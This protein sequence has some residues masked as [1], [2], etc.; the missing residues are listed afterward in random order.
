MSTTASVPAPASSRLRRVAGQP[1]PAEG[2]GGL[3]TQSWF[4]IALSAEIGTSCLRG[5]DFL[6]G[7]VI[8]FRDAEGTA[9]VMTAYCPHLGADLSV[10]DV[11]E[12]TVRC[13]FHHWRYDCT[14]RCVSTKVGDPPPAAARLYRFRSVE[15]YGI[16][17]AFNGDDPWWQ[18][19]SF[20]YPDDELTIRAIELP[21]TL[22]V[23]PWVLCC[24]T[25]DMQHI[26][27]LHGITFETG[28]PHDQIEWTDHSLMY[29]FAGLHRRGEQV[30]NRIGVFGTSLYY[31][32]TELDG[33][34]FGFLAPFGLPRPGTSRVFL[35]VAA[36]RD[37]GTAPEVE[38]FLDR[39][40]ALEQS[41]VGEDVA[42][43]QTIH[44][45]PGTL[46]A[47]DRTLGRYFQF[48]RSY[49]RAHPAAEFIK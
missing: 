26:K 8:V 17:W 30:S 19:P 46:T 11:Y 20:P 2:D 15:K 7:R 23:D 12:D 24:N 9:H 13:A 41:V 28:D 36:R 39:V 22:P 14:G 40:I 5:Y 18:L 32:A 31:Q 16:V 25:P 29:D 49:P 10:G 33:R 42:I 45:R 48:L 47:A 4:P 27:A 44:F 21:Q 37:S 1:I 35:V 3:F 38:A 43:M 34:W 6:D